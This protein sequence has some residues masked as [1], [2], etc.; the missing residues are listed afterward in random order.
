R[1]KQVFSDGTTT[2]TDTKKLVY[3]NQDTRLHFYPNPAQE[4]L[5]VEA[6]ELAGFAGNIMIVNMLG[7]VK[8]TLNLEK[9]PAGVIEIPLDR[10]DN[11]MHS[12]IIQVSGKHIRTELFVVEKMR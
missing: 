12:I 10:L 7:Q 6:R 2:Y 1:I 5:F 8:T 3:G 4:I 9:I 11:G